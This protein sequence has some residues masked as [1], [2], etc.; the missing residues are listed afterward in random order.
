MILEKIRVENVRKVAD[1]LGLDSEKI[2]DEYNGRDLMKNPEANDFI[3]KYKKYF[4]TMDKNLLREFYEKTGLILMN[5]I[6][7]PTK[8]TL[9]CS[10]FQELYCLTMYGFVHDHYGKDDDY[11]NFV[12]NNHL[13]SEIQLDFPLE[14]KDEDYYEHDYDKDETWGFSNEELEALHKNPKLILT[15]E[16]EHCYKTGP[17]RNLVGNFGEKFEL[18]NGELFRDGRKIEED[19][20]TL[21]RLNDCNTYIIF[22][23]NRIENLEYHATECELN[24][25][26]KKILYGTYFLAVLRDNKELEITL[27]SRADEAESYALDFCNVDDVEFTPSKDSYKNE[28]GTLKIKTGKNFI[29]FPIYEYQPFVRNYC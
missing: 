13:T 22:E 23:D 25:K 5:R 12:R 29:E 3:E 16:F 15:D 8:K 11:H 14:L 20:K 4:T 1:Y 26:Y 21:F 19:V 28:D 18:K 17:R 2:S 6:V 27:I 24:L 9:G 7:V 10:D